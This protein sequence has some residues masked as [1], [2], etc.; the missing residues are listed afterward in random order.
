MNVSFWREI[1]RFAI[2]FSSCCF[3][4][5]SARFCSSAMLFGRSS[6]YKCS[7]ESFCRFR[8]LSHY[9]SSRTPIFPP[10]KSTTPMQLSTFSRMVSLILSIWC[11][12]SPKEKTFGKTDNF[13][14][15]FCL[16][17][18]PF[19]SLPWV[20]FRQLRILSKTAEMRNK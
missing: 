19:V 10:R 12:G 18:P 6:R 3:I 5:L 20:S 14:S 8:Y 13:P 7:S 9:V 4:A 1:P 2:H 16:Q 17:L 15:S 11:S